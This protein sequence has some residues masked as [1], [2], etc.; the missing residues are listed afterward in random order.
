VTL[1]PGPVEFY[2]CPGLDAHARWH[3][4]IATGEERNVSS[5]RKS[6]KRASCTID[7]IRSGHTNKD[8]ENECMF[9]KEGDCCES[10]WCMIRTTPLNVKL[11]NLFAAVILLLCSLTSWNNDIKVL[12]LLELQLWPHSL[13]I[14][15]LSITYIRRFI[16]SLQYQ[17]QGSGPNLDL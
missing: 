14:A 13:S 6:Q 9:K 3:P 4:I 5:L 10:K 17:V 1:L 11:L 2:R 12:P 7:Q 15:A 8:L 16:C